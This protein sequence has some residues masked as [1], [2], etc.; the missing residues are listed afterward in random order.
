MKVKECSL[1]YA[2]KSIIISLKGGKKDYWYL[3]KYS[4]KSKTPF[5]FLN[6][7]NIVYYFDE[8]SEDILESKVLAIYAQSEGIIEIIAHK[9]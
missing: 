4:E 6:Y 8:L 2:N 7:E 1:C 3:V 9:E 5:Q